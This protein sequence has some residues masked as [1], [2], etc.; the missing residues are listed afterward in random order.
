[1]SD[2]KA[3]APASDRATTDDA[4]AATK[5]PPATGRERRQHER[6]ILR[7]LAQLVFK[8][9]APV[10]V[11]TLDISTGGLGFVTDANPPLGLVLQ[12]KLRI[13]RRPEGFDE[14]LVSG[15]VTHC[16]YCRQEGGFKVGL[17]FVQPSASFQ[18]CVQAFMKG[19]SS[20]GQPRP[21]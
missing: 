8:D 5:S 9:H 20:L 6:R 13:P 11:R 15:Q 14:H 3:P 17:A 21:G 7:T 19:S 16:A 18:S 1:M 2:L 12:L 4:A 10:T